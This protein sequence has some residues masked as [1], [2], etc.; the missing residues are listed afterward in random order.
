MVRREACNGALLSEQQEK[1]MSAW[2]T[3]NPLARVVLRRAVL[4]L[5]GIALGQSAEWLDVPPEH[6]AAIREAVCSELFWSSPLSALPPS[7]PLVP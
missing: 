3:E 2:L 7:Q 4:V 1:E 5:L 6:R